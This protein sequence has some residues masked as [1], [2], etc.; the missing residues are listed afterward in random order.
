MP[1]DYIVLFDVY[2]GNILN[3][4]NGA[5]VNVLFIHLLVVWVDAANKNA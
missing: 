2:C 5:F 4:N 1:R 3:N